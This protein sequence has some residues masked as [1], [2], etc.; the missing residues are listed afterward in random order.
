MFCRTSSIRVAAGAFV[1]SIFL[2]GAAAANSIPIEDHIYEPGYAVATF[3]SDS[4]NFT[5]PAGATNVL[6]NTTSW[7]VDDSAVIEVNGHIVLSTGIGAPGTGSFQF[8]AG[9]PQVPFT[10]T[11]GDNIGPL[12]SVNITGFTGPGIN[13][14]EFLLNNTGNGIIGPVSSGGG[15]TNSDFV[16][17][18]TFTA[19]APVPGA[20][21]AGLA[22]LALAGLYA[23]AH[24]A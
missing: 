10:F 23:R 12:P 4:Q 18:V 15:P 24:R 11:S 1:F 21:L 13:T 14:I 20:G 5:L 16:G 8:S 6:L 9:G 17:S 19:P 3:L 7:G 22:A 2:G